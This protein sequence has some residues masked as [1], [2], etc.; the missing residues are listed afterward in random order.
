LGKRCRW[1]RKSQR[2]EDYCG[3]RI[4]HRITILFVTLCFVSLAMF[5]ITLTTAN[6]ADV[7]DRL[8][9]KAKIVKGM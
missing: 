9:A 4:C 8:V 1:Q 6:T 7:K 2:D 5:I 3:G